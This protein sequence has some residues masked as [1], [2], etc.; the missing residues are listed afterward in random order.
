MNER[1]GCDELQFM[2]SL[3]IRWKQRFSNY[4]KAL[5]QLE[6]F[7]NKSPLSS[8]EEQG[9]IKS[10]EYTFELGWNTL[11]DFFESQGEANIQGSKDAIRL[12]FKR[13]LVDDGEVW[14]DMVQSRIQTAHTYNE[15]VAK[16]VI[17]SVK[18]KYVD[19]FKKLKVKLDAQQ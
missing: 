5:A 18:H 9:F 3:D 14:M 10:F 1:L 17:N 11:K 4:S 6:I 16:E 15:K 12:A 2:T 13:G 7:D 19:A 8:L